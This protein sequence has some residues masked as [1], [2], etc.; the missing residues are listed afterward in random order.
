METAVGVIA[1]VLIV[2]GFGPA[3]RGTKAAFD[4]FDNPGKQETPQE[5]QQAHSDIWRLLLLVAVAFGL[6]FV[7]QM[8]E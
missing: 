1:I 6:L 3:T 7:L 4:A 5:T 8:G 2:L